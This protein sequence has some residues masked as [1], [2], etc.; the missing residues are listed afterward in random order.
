MQT[1]LSHSHSKDFIFHF[2]IHSHIYS[3]DFF[4]WPLYA[5][6]YVKYWKLSSKHNRVP[7]LMYLI[8]KLEQNRTEFNM[9]IVQRVGGRTFQAKGTTHVK[10]MS[11]EQGSKY[12]VAKSYQAGPCRA[13]VARCT[14]MVL[15]LCWRTHMELPVWAYF[16]ASFFIAEEACY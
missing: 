13:D 6:H 15:E 4:E 3:I 2:F 16:S 10:T 5:R 14:K 7:D 1:P 9:W 12:L 8:I 11:G